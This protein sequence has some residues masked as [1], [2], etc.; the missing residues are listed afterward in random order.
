MP[1]ASLLGRRPSAEAVSHVRTELWDMLPIYDQI[2][3]T[4]C[5]EYAVKKKTTRYL[6]IPNSAEN[7]ESSP[8]YQEYLQRA[9]FYNVVE[10]TA[11]GLVGQ[12]F[13][14][15]PSLTLPP[16]MEMLR[17]NANGEGLSFSQLMKEACMHILPYGRGGFL[18]DFPIADNNETIMISDLRNKRTQPTLKF[19]KPWDIVNWETKVISGE[20]VLTMVVLRET[21]EYRAPGSYQVVEYEQY[22]VYEIFEGQVVGGIYQLNKNR[23]FQQTQNFQLRDAKSFPFD[24]VPFA[25]VGADNNDATID[26]APLYAMSVLNIAHYRNSA[27]YEET[28]YFMG[29]PTL[30]INGVDKAWVEDVWKKKLYLGSRSVVPAPPNANETLIQIQENSLAKEGMDQKEEQMRAL[31]AKLVE[32]KSNV[33]RKEAEI[34]IEAASDVSTLTKIA[35]NVEEAATQALRWCA[36]YV[37]ANEAE[38]ELEINRN[39]DLTSLT[40]EELRQLKEMYDSEN[41]LMAFEEY[42]RVLERSGFTYL[43]VDEARAKIDE[44]LT[45]RVEFQRIMMEATQPPAPVA[46]AA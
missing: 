38:I 36:R 28:I 1:R 31:G 16:Q 32:R 40:A 5:G 7:L 14:R 26:K 30:F 6:P 3:D 18:A 37:G 4:M 39:F 12:I 17:E 24:R 19:Y 27:D 44:E 45:K 23:D 29:Q 22:R 43:T 15:D 21:F 35:G 10:R 9:V 11:E 33:E 41:P 25:F 2:R 13:L 8:R 42:R 20:T 46:T 34:M